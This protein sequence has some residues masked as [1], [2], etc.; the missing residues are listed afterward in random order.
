MNISIDVRNALVEKL[1]VLNAL[2]L[3][4]APRAA[5][6]FVS[7]KDFAINVQIVMYVNNQMGNVLNAPKIMS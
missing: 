2:F 7:S 4:N 6:D 3:I 5:L 1:G